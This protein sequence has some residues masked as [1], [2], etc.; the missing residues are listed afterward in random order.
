MRCMRF[1]LFFP[2]F[3]PLLRISLPSVIFHRHSYLMTF[4]SHSTGRHQNTKP[5]PFAE[6]MS[7]PSPGILR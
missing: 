3:S 2:W 1:I 7:L 6:A 5:D 4:L